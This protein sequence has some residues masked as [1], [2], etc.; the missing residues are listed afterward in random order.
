M[1]ATPSQL[2]ARRRGPSFT[3]A[4]KPRA[5]ADSRSLSKNKARPRHTKLGLEGIHRFIVASSTEGLGSSLSYS[6]RRPTSAKAI[7]AETLCPHPRRGS[8]GLLL[9]G[10]GLFSEACK[11]RFLF[12]VLRSCFGRYLA[13]CRTSSP[14]FFSQ[15]SAATRAGSW[16]SPT[17]GF[18]RTAYLQ[19]ASCLGYRRTL[20]SR[21]PQARST[22]RVWLRCSNSPTP[23]YP[24]DRDPGPL[25]PEPD[26]SRWR[27]CS[28]QAHALTADVAGASSSET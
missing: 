10:R 2:C 21:L 5:H 3:R 27:S 8:S 1:M 23:G 22:A 14:P 26:N 6:A 25:A 20:I 13:A 17:L 11:A 16:P 18:K 12:I 9:I 15:R 24:R 4:W 7:G 28:A 19:L